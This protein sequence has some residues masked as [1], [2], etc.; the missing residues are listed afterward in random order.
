MKN[1]LDQ[2]H[3]EISEIEHLQDFISN[4]DESNAVSTIEAIKTSNLIQTPCNLKIMIKIIGRLIKYRKKQIQCFF[5]LID[6]I[7]P[8]ISA[9]FSKSEIMHLFSQKII[10]LKFLHDKYI[11]VEDLVNF[12]GVGS[13]KIQY[14]Y[15]EVKNYLSKNPFFLSQLEEP[16]KY[17]Y[18]YEYFTSKEGE[19]IEFAD[20]P[21][22]QAGNNDKLSILIQKDDIDTFQKTV[23]QNNIDIRHH[24]IEISNFELTKSFP[25]RSA[26]LIEYAA[27]HGSLKIFKFLLINNTTFSAQLFQ[28]A[29]CGRNNEIIHLAEKMT[30]N[31]DISDSLINAMS[32]SII[33]HYDELSEYLY[34]NYEIPMFFKDFP[35]SVYF[36]NYSFFFNHINDFNNEYEELLSK[37]DVTGDDKETFDTAK[38]VIANIITMCAGNV[39]PILLKIAINFKNADLNEPIQLFFTK[40]IWEN[41]GATNPLTYAIQTFNNENAKFLISLDSV[42]LDYKLSDRITPFIWACYVGNM[43]M[44]E[45][46]YS[47]NV[48]ASIVIQESNENALHIATRRDHLDV[49]KF[50]ID[51]NI[52]DLNIKNEQGEAA[53]DTAARLG[54]KEIFNFLKS[55]NGIEFDK[56]LKPNEERYYP[57]N[58]KSPISMRTQFFN[59]LKENIGSCLLI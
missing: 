33:F 57:S 38:V 30:K 13:T 8:L 4:L 36:E 5:T 43:E 11:T 40:K 19:N 16:S 17:K 10:F 50:L 26:T 42:D 45:L 49:V 22:L 25:E 12:Y 9:N 2:Y 53:I 27:F 41:N 54:Y 32:L 31:I 58:F 47:K 37:E 35:T 55:Q 14:F 34:E 39:C 20:D 28:C 51:L 23:S 21:R 44:V 52:Y 56:E 24:K 48:D 1:C 59:S 7:F 46:L 6:E 15:P 18:I 3:K 29:F